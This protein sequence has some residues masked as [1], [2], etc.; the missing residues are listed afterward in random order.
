[1]SCD[2]RRRFRNTNIP[3]YSLGWHL[4]LVLVFPIDIVKTILQSNTKPNPPR[5]GQIIRTILAERGA[6][7]FYFGLAPALIRAV[8]ANIAC[9]GAVEATHAMINRYNCI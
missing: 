3:V 2:K 7:G 5:V 4:R 8:P 9:F 1:M 6:A